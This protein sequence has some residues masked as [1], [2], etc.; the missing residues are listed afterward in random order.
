[1]RK[2]PKNKKAYGELY[3]TSDSDIMLRI[4]ILPAAV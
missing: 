3:C 4:V 1:V 2:P